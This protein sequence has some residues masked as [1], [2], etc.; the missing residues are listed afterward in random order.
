MLEDQLLKLIDAEKIVLFCDKLY[1]SMVCMVLT[2]GK[3]K[4]IHTSWL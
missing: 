1:V 2:N 4:V 3:Y